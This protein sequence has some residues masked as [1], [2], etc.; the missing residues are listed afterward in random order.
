M[1]YLNFLKKEPKV[2]INAITNYGIDISF[3]IYARR[4][5]LMEKG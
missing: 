4:K 3:F 5:I 2:L 1:F